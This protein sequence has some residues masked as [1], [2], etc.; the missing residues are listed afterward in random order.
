MAVNDKNQI[1]TDR[2]T[3][4]TSAVWKKSIQGINSDTAGVLDS[5]SNR[6]NI[7]EAMSENTPR[8]NQRLEIR[9]CSE[10]NRSRLKELKGMFT[11]SRVLST[12]SD[13]CRSHA[14]GD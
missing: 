10:E 9:I 12:G 5:T 2:S 8:K 6:E 7:P 14:A 1:S 3:C 4:T 11:G 13:C